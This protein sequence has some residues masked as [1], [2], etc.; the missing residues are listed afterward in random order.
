MAPE[1]ERGDAASADAR[2]DVYALGALL[3]WLLDPAHGGAGDSPRAV[4]AIRDRAMRRDP[5]TRYPTAEAFGVELARYLDG[6]RVEAH[7]ETAIE[8]IA[9]FGRT[10]RVAILLV[11]AYLIM[12]ITC[13]SM[14]GSVTDRGN[15]GNPGLESQSGSACPVTGRRSA[16]GEVGRDSRP[17]LH[18][19]PVPL[20]GVSDDQSDEAAGQHDF[21]PVVAAIGLWD[22][23]DEKRQQQPDA[24]SHQEARRH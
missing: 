23:R 13:C 4:V 12:R 10:Y 20:R 14:A 22:R 16:D 18:G 8:R 9:R 21:P 3:G 1:Q 7:Q 5:G 19:A 2:A 15:L 6:L 17:A 11:V 24:E